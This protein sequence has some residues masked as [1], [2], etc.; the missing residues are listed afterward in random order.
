MESRDGHGRRMIQGRAGNGQERRGDEAQRQLAMECRSAPCTGTTSRG[1]GQH[2]HCRVHVAAARTGGTRRRAPC[3][4][5]TCITRRPA[6]ARGAHHSG[7]HGDHGRER[8]DANGSDD[9]L[10]S[11]LESA[12][13]HGAWGRRWS[14]AADRA[15]NDKEIE[16]NP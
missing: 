3:T 12:L 11:W 7:R 6:E 9:G 16:C 1:G 13:V 15:E 4:G 14:S 2:G 8:S 5:T 10:W